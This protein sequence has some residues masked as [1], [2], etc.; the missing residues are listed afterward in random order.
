MPS[1]ALNLCVVDRVGSRARSRLVILRVSTA[2]HRVSFP[3]L[4]PALLLCDQPVLGL[5]MS[6]LSPSSASTGDVGTV[7][8]KPPFET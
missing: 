6:M 8:I 5:V 4:V 7:G 2:V 1:S 3:M